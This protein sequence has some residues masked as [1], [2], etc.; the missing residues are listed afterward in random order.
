MHQQGRL[1]EAVAGATSKL[2]ELVAKLVT[3]E[4]WIKIGQEDAKALD[5]YRKAGN[6]IIELDAEVQYAARKIGLD[7]ADEDRPRTTPGSR[8]CSR[9]SASSRSSGRAPTLAQR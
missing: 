7:W 9:A 6:E 4:S 8:R 5:F 2:V 1:G 3:F